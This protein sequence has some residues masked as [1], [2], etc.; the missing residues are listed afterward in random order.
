[1]ALISGLSAADATKPIIVSALLIAAFADNLT[2]A[3]S[4][5][6]FQE[7]EQLDQKNAFNG[8][9]TNFVTRLLLSISFV[10]LVVLL[11]LEHVAKVSIVWGILLL[12][13]LTYLVA[14]ERKVKP[15]R[16]V[17]KYLLVASAVIIV[18]TLIPNWI[19]VLL[20]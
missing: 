4:I 5:H 18:S 6:I 3:L 1:M 16:E 2:D 19:G 17:V 12:V 8:T 9:I 13:I 11:P 10:L 20:G 14:R 7:S 15:L